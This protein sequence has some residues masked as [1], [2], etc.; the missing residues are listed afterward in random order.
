MK[1]T[2]S[3]LALPQE[4][5]LAL[6]THAPMVNPKSGNV[7]HVFATGHGL[8]FG[9][10][11]WAESQG[12]LNLGASLLFRVRVEPDPDIPMINFPARVVSLFPELAGKWTTKTEEYFSLVGMAKFPGCGGDFDA[13]V[14]A[15]LEYHVSRTIF[16]SLKER[17]PGVTFLVDEAQFQALFHHS[18]AE[19]MAP[20]SQKDKAPVIQLF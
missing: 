12:G 4:L 2:T 18:L 13:L 7:F 14:E 1:A 6:G 3:S 8:R 15:D 16:G 11:V 19:Y 9:L 17:L 20:I 10:R 5:A